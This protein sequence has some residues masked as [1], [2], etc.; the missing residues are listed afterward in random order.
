[1]L[2][3]SK[4]VMRYWAVR[5]GNYVEVRAAS[6][7]PRKVVSSLTRTDKI[8]GWTYEYDSYGNPVRKKVTR[9][10]KRVLK[11]TVYVGGTVLSLAKWG[12]HAYNALKVLVEQDGLVE[13]TREQRNKFVKVFGLIKEA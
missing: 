6:T 4:R 12:G 9:D 8:D 1:M 5:V 11:Q 13:I 2:H 3:S 7:K 10:K